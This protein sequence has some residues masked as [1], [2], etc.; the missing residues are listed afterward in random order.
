MLDSL[1]TKTLW[2]YIGFNH[3]AE[4]LTGISLEEQDI[5]YARL[6]SRLAARDDIHPYFKEGLAIALSKHKTA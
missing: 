1:D 3:A 2:H 6:F 5:H 4:C